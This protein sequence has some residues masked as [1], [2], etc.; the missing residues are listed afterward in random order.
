MEQEWAAYSFDYPLVIYIFK[1]LSNSIAIY[2]CG[3]LH[4][5]VAFVQFKNREKHSFMGVFHVFKI[6]Q[7]LPNRATYHIFKYLENLVIEKIWYYF[8]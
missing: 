3:A 5:L 6:V 4:D 7:M 8:E 1:Y 2:I